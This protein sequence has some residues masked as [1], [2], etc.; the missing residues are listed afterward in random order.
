MEQVLLHMHRERGRHAV[1]SSMHMDLYL[2]HDWNSHPPFKQGRGIPPL[3]YLPPLKRHYRKRYRC[4]PESHNSSVILQS[5]SQ[6]PSINFSYLNRLNHPYLRSDWKP[7]E[8]PKR[9]R[10]LMHHTRS[11]EAHL[12]SLQQTYN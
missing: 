2:Q 8:L 9:V 11:L 12:K 6:L 7:A 4:L 5:T 3:P 10:S 1:G